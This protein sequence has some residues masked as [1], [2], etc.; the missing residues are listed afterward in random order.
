[1]ILG[2]KGPSVYFEI[3][4]CIVVVASDGSVVT[5]MMKRAL[6]INLFR[7]EY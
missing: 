1:M 7:S 4:R 3:G 6:Y 2:L 5:V